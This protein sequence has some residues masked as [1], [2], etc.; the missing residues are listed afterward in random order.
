MKKKSS[1]KKKEIIRSKG[2]RAM[3]EE[4]HREN[5]KKNN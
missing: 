1:Y 4:W 3:Q 5:Y 2:E